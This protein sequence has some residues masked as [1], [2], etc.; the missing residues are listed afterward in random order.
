V[1]DLDA[2]CGLLAGLRFS[3]EVA[4]LIA[5]RHISAEKKTVSLEENRQ[6]PNEELIL[7]RYE[8]EA[9]DR[10]LI[11]EELVNNI[12]SAGKIVRLVEEAGGEVAGIMC[13]INRSFP[14]RNT[15]VPEEGRPPIPI[16][17][18]IERETPQYRQDDPEA[19]ALV[20]A[21]NIIWKPKVEHWPRLQKVMEEYGLF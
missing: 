21:G 11:G 10:V 1:E 19:V 2:L 7:G 6:R 15:Y 16:V 13:A 12:S 20:A 14:F 3:Q 18:V 5:C 17:S 9:G 8:V 4:R